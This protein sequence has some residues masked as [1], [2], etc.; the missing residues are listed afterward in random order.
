[1]YVP[2][3]TSMTTRTE[4]VQFCRLTVIEPVPKSGVTKVVLPHV[5]RA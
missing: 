4:E 3:A 1:M 5:T 2:E